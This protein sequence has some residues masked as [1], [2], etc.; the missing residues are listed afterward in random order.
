MKNVFEKTRKVSDTIVVVLFMVLVAIVILQVFTRFLKIPQTW[1]DETSKFIFV[2]VTYI[3]GSITVS[4][5]MNITF[6]LILDS[7]KGKAFKVLFTLVNICCIVF[8]AAMMIL[9]LR[10]A[11]M[12]RIQSSTM[13]HVNMGLMNLAIP[14][15][16]F[17]MILSQIEYY[18]RVMKEREE[19]E[20]S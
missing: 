11:W 14:I 19:S 6:D 17:L 15:G 13:L 16:C 1:I 5:G 18:F 3:G 20:R 2:W 12:N 10:N 9:G 4:R 7:R 8:L